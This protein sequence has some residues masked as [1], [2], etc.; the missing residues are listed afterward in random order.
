MTSTLRLN[1]VGSFG[2]PERDS[3]LTHLRH[4]SLLTVF[5]FRRG[6]DNQV[7]SVLGKN[8]DL[9]Q[10]ITYLIYAI[11]SHSEWVANR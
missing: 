7:M 2:A 11:Y 4:S 1:V 9:L 5:C 10:V 3:V 6:A 8:C